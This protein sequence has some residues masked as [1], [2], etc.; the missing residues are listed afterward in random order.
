MIT[1]KQDA[2]GTA[3]NKLITKD[4]GFS[5]LGADGVMSFSGSFA[6]G[7]GATAAAAAT[8]G[9]AYTS[10]STGGGAL[11]L[12]RVVNSFSMPFV[13]G[14]D[15]VDVT[16]ADPFNMSTRTVGGKTTRTSYAY[17]SIDRA[18]ELIRDPEALEANLVAM[19]GISNASLTKKLIQVCEARADMLAVID[20]PNVYI[21]SAEEICNDEERV[22]RTTPEKSAKNLIARR[23]N[24]SY[25]CTYYPWVK[26]QDDRNANANVWVPPSCVALGVMAN[27]EEKNA[28][29]FAP[30]GFNRGGLGD[31]K[32]SGLAVQAVSEVLLSTQRDKLYSANINPI[33]SFV[34]EGLVVFGQKTL[35][36]T[37][38]AL[39]R[40][41][42]R[43][44]LIFVKKQI[45]FYASQLL[46]DQNLP[47]TWNRFTGQV[48]P[49]LESVKTRL[50]LADFKVVLDRSTTTPDLVD[51]N[52]M[53]A[54]IF[55]KPAR[56]IEFIAVDF[57]IT[58]SGASFENPF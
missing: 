5:Q 6:G 26:I 44:L 27:T 33:A 41:N 56:A 24:S 13:G 23:V 7:L 45:S 58:R 39:D 8:N 53:Y 32:N 35:Q 51:R 17:A 34:A 36:M 46:F 48:V 40:I 29:W 9:T 3:G 14:C 52:I 15:G 28:V 10:L 37:P 18:I 47:A 42:V 20:L 25:G 49:F 19:P 55:L 16:E 38:S 12:L 30:A 43:R 57:V 1:L 54:K 22:T 11:E 50:G 2:G 31:P 4:A 21:P